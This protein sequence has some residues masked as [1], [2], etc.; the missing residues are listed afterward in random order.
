MCC[1]PCSVCRVLPALDEL[2]QGDV[3]AAAVGELMYPHIA[4]AVE[5]CSEEAEQLLF[6]G[7]DIVPSTLGRLSAALPG[8]TSRACFLGNARFSGTD[9]AAYRGPKPQHQE[10]SR[11]ELDATAAG[12]RRET[13][14]CRRQCAG[15]GLPYI[16]GAV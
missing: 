5:V 15:L 4:E 14:R 16:D 9:L 6:E 1:G 12:I 7:P 8:I 13:D 3:S 2:D 11:A 10:A